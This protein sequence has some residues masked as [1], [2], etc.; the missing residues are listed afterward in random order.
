MFGGKDEELEFLE[1][2]LAALD[3][4]EYDIIEKI[5][6]EKTSVRGYSRASGFSRRTIC[7]ERDRIIGLLQ[8][9]F[10]IR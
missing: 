6:I 1:K 2:C 3:E 9:F 8:R 4:Y 10:E 5:C 7:N